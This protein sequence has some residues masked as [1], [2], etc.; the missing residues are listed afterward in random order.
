MTNGM[1]QDSAANDSLAKVETIYRMD[2]N[3]TYP[4][5]V[6]RVW[7]AISNQ[8]EITAWMKFTTKLEPRIGGAIHID[9]SSQGSLEG[10]VCNLESPRLLIYAWGDSLV[11]WELEEVSGT[12]RLH[13]S[14]VGVLPDLL[15]GL[16]AGWHAFLDQLEDHLMGSS[17]PNRYRELKSRYEEERKPGM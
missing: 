16:G 14:H 3:R 12:T 15:T 4:Q 5:S 9:F 7:A 17:R 6:E 2:W 13:L 1:E 10:I 11:K 8:D